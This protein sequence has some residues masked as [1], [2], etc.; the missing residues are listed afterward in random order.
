VDLVHLTLNDLHYYHY[1]PSRPPYY[2]SNYL[3]DLV[4]LPKGRKLV[5]CKWVYQTKYALDG[6]I[7]RHK[8]RLVSKG[9]SQVE[10]IDYNETFAPVAKMNSIHL[11]LALA[12]S[13]KWEVHQIDVKSA[14]LHGDLKE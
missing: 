4:P 6:S 9:F 10:G 14:F 1:G 8:A 12:T 5:I 7:E 3:T 13:H 2:L 11:V